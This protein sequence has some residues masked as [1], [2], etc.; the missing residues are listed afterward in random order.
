MQGIP[1][2]AALDLFFKQD[3]CDRDLGLFGELLGADHEREPVVG[4]TI[5]FLLD[6]IL[7]EVEVVVNWLFPYWIHVMEVVEHPLCVGFEKAKNVP[8]NGL[9]IKLPVG[10]HLPHHA[11]DMTLNLIYRHGTSLKSSFLNEKGQQVKGNIGC[12]IVLFFPGGSSIDLEKWVKTPEM[13]HPLV[14]IL[15]KLR[16]IQ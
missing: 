12:I 6:I 3:Q 2:R 14:Y 9:T 16:I 5:S 8:G 10:V 11:P 13:V 7:D 15:K 4:D 1:E